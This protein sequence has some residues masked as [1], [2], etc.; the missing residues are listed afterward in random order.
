M[1]PAD[2][3]FSRHSTRDDDDHGRLPDPYPCRLQTQAALHAI[4]Q[5]D[6]RVADHPVDR[7]MATACAIEGSRRGAADSAVERYRYFRDHRRDGRLN[8][9]YG[10]LGVFERRFLAAGVQH[11]HF[12][13]PA[14]MEYQL[15][16]VCL[17]ADR[18]PG[19]C[20]YAGYHGHNVFGDSVQGPHFY[21]PFRSSWSSPA[22]MV[23][24]VG[25]VCGALSNFGAAAAIANGV[26]AVTMGE[27]GHCAYAVMVA[28]G[29]WVPAYS[30]S[31]S[32]GVHTAFDGGSWGWHLFTAAGQQDP[33][34]SRRA[35]DLRRLG[36]WQL[37]AGLIPDS[38][39]TLA[40]ACRSCPL[41]YAL[42][43]ARARALVTAKA[44]AQAWISFHD[45]ALASLAEDHPEVAWELLRQ[46]AYPHVL[47]AGDDTLP[48][49][50]RRL[51]AFHEALSGWG[52]CRWDFATAIRRQQELLSSDLAEQDAFAALVFGMHADDPALAAA[53]LESQFGVI[54]NDANRRQRF[55]A[56]IFEKVGPDG[57]TTS[58]DTIS[59]MARRLCPE[60]AAAGDKA[61][62]Q[63]IGRLAG[64]RHPPCDMEPEPFPG[65]LLSSG[66]TLAV[67]AAG[68]RYDS[69]E[70]H[71]GVIEP[72]GGY[73]HTDVQPATVRVQLGNFGRLSG[74]VIVQRPGHIERLNGARLQV[75]IDGEQWT[76]VHTFQDVKRVERIDLE[77]RDI[78]AG[79]V[80]V[81]QDHGRCLHFNRFLVY[82]TKKTDR[83][84]TLAASLVILSAT[85][86][87]AAA[88]LQDFPA[89]REAART[90]GVPL[91]VCVH[92]GQW[93]QASRTF[94]EKVW[95]SDALAHELDGQVVLAEIGIGQSL[96][97]ACHVEAVE[98]LNRGA[99]A[100]RAAGL[101]LW[102]S[103]RYL[104]LGLPAGQRGILHLRA[105]NA[106]GRR[107]GVG[108]A[109]GPLLPAGPR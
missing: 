40:N 8:D 58:A 79:F 75:S 37:A 74:V 17:P 43:Q 100:Q 96:D 28:P 35:G 56:A 92:G 42:W 94:L 69:P 12:N 98:V 14:S 80:R 49:R 108:A 90:Q 72:H 15:A 4:W 31:W 61:T 44:D 62:F 27:P 65:I 7:A 24:N 107:P 85:A 88:P 26:P 57:T 106:F 59:E 51:A 77:G 38:L 66:G 2:A 21:E 45:D 48:E 52:V 78:D 86:L 50:Q 46:H 1:P 22:E 9:L 82:G 16:E 34:D 23:R 64:R 109:A 87:P 95:R 97:E 39:A 11:Q 29:R 70:T 13:T 91:A 47:P 73:F 63:F 25:G 41:D 105:V 20:W 99:N 83:L 5:A 81:V 60:A 103:A 102:V 101:T 19:A 89:A 6:P 93:Q 36:E 33:A 53:V 30:L 84:L 71:W 76:D 54:G 68:N 67:A 3:V 55:L 104:K 10:T 32:R 18:Y